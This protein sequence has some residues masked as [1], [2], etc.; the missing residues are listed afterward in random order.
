EFRSL[1]MK[2]F[3][4]DEWRAYL[5]AQAREYRI[6]SEEHRPAITISRET[7]AAAITIGQ[8]V[9]DSV[10]LLDKGRPHFVGPL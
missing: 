6:E 3:S 10:Q 5:L 4:L 9:T 1:R 7:G 2:N 8:M